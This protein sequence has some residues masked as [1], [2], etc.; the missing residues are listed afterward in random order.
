MYATLLPTWTACREADA[1]RNEA[2]AKWNKASAKRNE[3]AAK[4]NE[5]HAKWT[6]ARVKWLA[7]VRKVCGPEALIEWGE[8]G[9]CTVQ[10]VMVF[11]P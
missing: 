1:K 9:S 7:A 10:G 5:A 3:A 2:V 6:G 4:W 11:L 8:D